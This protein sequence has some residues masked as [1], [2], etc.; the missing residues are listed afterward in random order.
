MIPVSK[1]HVDLRQRSLALIFKSLTGADQSSSSPLP[2]A[3]G[4][5]P[6]GCSRPKEAQQ[7]DLTNVLKGACVSLAKMRDTMEGDGAT[8]LVVAADVLACIADLEALPVTPAQLKASMLGRELNHRFWREHCNVEVS[9]RSRALVAKWKATLAEKRSR[10]DAG[11]EILLSDSIWDLAWA[12][13]A[14]ARCAQNV[15]AAA[16]SKFAAKVEQ[17]AGVK[18]SS[19]WSKTYKGKVRFLAHVLRRPENT[20]LRKLAL[21]G[22]VTGSSLVDRSEEDFLSAERKAEKQRHREE[23][24]RDALSQQVS[25]D[26]YDAD[27]EC[28]LCHKSGAKYA[29]ICDTGSVPIDGS[30]GHKRQKTKKRIHAQCSTCGERWQHDDGWHV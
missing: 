8:G 30:S 21:D 7:L 3:N 14:A 26:L 6:D 2:A 19:D 9:S 1:P 13:V 24:L 27:L 15:E 20:E 4:Q 12:E 18:D 22:C 16:W 10:V 25:L 11:D 5:D 29:V 17:Q 23:G 28:P